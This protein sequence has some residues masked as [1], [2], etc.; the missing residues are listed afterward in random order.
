MNIPQFLIILIMPNKPISMHEPLTD[1][2]VMQ[3][4]QDLT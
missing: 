2:A 1:F 3:Q 4:T